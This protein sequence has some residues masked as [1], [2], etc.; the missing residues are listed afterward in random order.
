MSGS[1]G[2]RMIKDKS[3]SA[4]EWGSW[5]GGSTKP[6]SQHSTANNA[7]R[8]AFQEHWFQTAGIL[9]ISNIRPG[10]NGFNAKLH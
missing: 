10:F 6:N 1:Q 4:D 7:D 5:G 3:S 2:G 8:L 9:S